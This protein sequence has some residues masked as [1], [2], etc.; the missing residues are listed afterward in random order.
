MILFSD[1]IWAWMKFVNWKTNK[2]WTNQKNNNGEY[3][4]VPIIAY[5]AKVG[6][7]RASA[8]FVWKWDSIV[9]K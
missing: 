8:G 5:L 7:S 1:E 2:T 9:Y 6:L 4:K 3:I